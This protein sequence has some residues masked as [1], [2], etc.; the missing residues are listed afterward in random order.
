MA[1]RTNIGK[2]TAAIQEGRRAFN[3]VDFGPVIP[4]SIQNTEYAVADW[5][6]DAVDPNIF[7][8]G[9]HKWATPNLR[10]TK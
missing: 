1:V 10:V 4:S 2:I 9:V 8:A 3:T 6:V 5:G 7:I